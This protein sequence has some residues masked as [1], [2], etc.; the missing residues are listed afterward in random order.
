METSAL[1]SN[2]LLRQRHRRKQTVKRG[3]MN[4]SLLPG[5][6][7]P[8]VSLR[9]RYPPARP[10]DRSIQRFT[11]GFSVRNIS[12]CFYWQGEM[13]WAIMSLGLPLKEAQI[14]G[15]RGGIK[16]CEWTLQ[17]LARFPPPLKLGRA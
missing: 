4:R 16:V 12:L 1:Q 17:A 2:R 7:I 6:S 8:Y 9:D 15:G 3:G 13:S 5:H 10:P 14:N 11:A